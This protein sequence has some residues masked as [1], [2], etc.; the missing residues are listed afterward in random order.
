MFTSKLNQRR[1]SAGN[2]EYAKSAHGEIFAKRPAYA[3][4]R[5]SHD[6]N[7]IHCVFHFRLLQFNTH[8]SPSLNP[9][10]TNRVNTFSA[11]S[12]SFPSSFGFPSNIANCG[13]RSA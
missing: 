8:H 10:I 2:T 6:V 1:P 11:A 7:V 4:T 9:A 12:K 5:A 13:A 3:T